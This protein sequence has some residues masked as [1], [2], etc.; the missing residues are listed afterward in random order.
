MGQLNI[1]TGFNFAIS[2]Y[3]QTKMVQKYVYIV[4]LGV[5]EDIKSKYYKNYTELLCNEMSTAS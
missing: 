3:S 5:F 4:F 1:H 2:S